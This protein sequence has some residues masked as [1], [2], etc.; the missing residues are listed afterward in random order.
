MDL[1][2]VGRMNER[3]KQVRRRLGER[4]AA[5]ETS[6]L[7]DD[8][9]LDLYASKSA[10]PV[11]AKSTPGHSHFS[12]VGVDVASVSPGIDLRSGFMRCCLMLCQS[13]PV[14]SSLRP[15]WPSSSATSLPIL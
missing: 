12:P 8:L 9:E 2:W 4:D 10:S 11:A 5:Y 14:S 6:F 13:A 3:R 1:P 15:N 7:G